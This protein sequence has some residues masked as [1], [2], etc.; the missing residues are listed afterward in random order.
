MQM[1]LDLAEKA[2]GATSPN[3]LVGCVIVSP[4]G[5]VVGKGYHHKAGEPHAEIN[6]MDDAGEKTAGATAYVTLEPCSHYGRTGPCCEALIKAGIK[7][8][9]AAATDPNPRV[10]GRGFRRLEEA[11]VLI[12]LGIPHRVE[13]ADGVAE[14]VLLA[15][16]V[17]Q[18][19]GLDEVLINEP[20]LTLAYKAGAEHLPQQAEGRVRDAVGA[21]LAG[22]LMVIEHAKA[23]IIHDA[24]EIVRHHKAAGD[25]DVR[26]DDLQQRRCKHVV[27][28][29][30]AGMGEAICRNF[31]NS[32]TS[33]SFFGNSISHFAKKEQRKAPAVGGQPGQ[34]YTLTRFLVDLGEHFCVAARQLS[35]NNQLC[36]CTTID[37]ANAGHV[38]LFINDLSIAVRHI[39]CRIVELI[40]ID[41]T[42]HI[43]LDALSIELLS[44]RIRIV[45]SREGKRNNLVSN[46]DQ[47]LGFLQFIQNPLFFYCDFS[48]FAPSLFPYSSILVQVRLFT[49]VSAVSL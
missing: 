42:I 27:R 34:R 16:I 43:S 14:A 32:N 11:G 3:P 9:V 37:S 19:E 33:F 7:K 5:H 29:E 21:G 45:F 18:I 36:G 1:A 2:R 20:G 49:V 46:V 22:L 47:I 48:S 44:E 24:V 25:P 40:C 38:A 10:S 41:Y 8:V 30:L 28:M 23:D 39:F 15:G 17:V 6:A 12:L 13:E 31:H 35:R 4:D 26:P